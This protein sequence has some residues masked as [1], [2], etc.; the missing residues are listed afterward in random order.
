MTSHSRRQC[1]WYLLPQKHQIPHMPISLQALVH[2][3]S[4]SNSVMLIPTLSYIWFQ[5]YIMNCWNLYHEQF[6]FGILQPYSL[7]RNR[8]NFMGWINC[9]KNTY[10][11]KYYWIY[12]QFNT[13][14]MIS[15]TQNTVKHSNHNFQSWVNE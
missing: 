12:N 10:L 4:L 9:S 11:K 6:L 5:K 1:T 3:F 8:F 13:Q 15:V 2:C 7:Y 14:Y